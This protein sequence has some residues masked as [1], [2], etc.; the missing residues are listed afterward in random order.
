VV[1]RGVPWVVPVLPSARPGPSSW[2]AT[3][4]GAWLTIS[5]ATSGARCNQVRLSVV[6]RAVR[7]LKE[8]TRSF[9]PVALGAAG[10]GT[11]ACW[12]G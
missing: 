4:P 2:S 6:A 8:A 3:T 10:R 12:Y 11:T 9:V 7:T 5:A 1:W